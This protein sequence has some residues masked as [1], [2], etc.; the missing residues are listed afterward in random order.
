MDNI[1]HITAVQT[2]IVW[3]N[4]Q[5]TLSL[6]D[7]HLYTIQGE[8][9]LIILPEMFTSGFTMD[10]AEVAEKVKGA[11]MYW[12][13]NQ[14]LYFGAAVCGSIVCKDGDNF[15]NRFIWME[16]DGSFQTYDK[17]HLFRMGQE[18]QVYRKGQ[19]KSKLIINYKGWNIC[20]LICYDLRFPVWSRNVNKEYDLLIYVAN[21]P[22]VRAYPWTQLLKA[23]AI[24]NQTYVAGIN[25]VGTDGNDIAYSGDSMIIDYKGE[26]L[27]TKPEKQAVHT[28][29]IFLK[30]LNDFRERFP[31]W[32]D[33]DEF[34]LQ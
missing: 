28:Q 2:D 20:P 34:Y 7:E 10:A 13:E 17:K 21:W 33:A 22:A 3:E 4:P 29:K 14:A 18:N 16:P 32:M 26:V 15:Y 31:V 5:R 1:L 9:D 24:E 12:M 6:I 25:R 19:E 8:T 23:R 27:W 11:T 30:K